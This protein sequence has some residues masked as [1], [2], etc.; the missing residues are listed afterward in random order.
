LAPALAI[1]A[2]AP[3]ITAPYWEEIFYRGLIYP[4]LGSIMP[5]S[6]ATPLSA[7]V[8]AVHHARVDALIPL[9]V[10]G[11][12]WATLYLLSGNL[13]VCMVVH[14]MW[15]SRIFLGSYLGF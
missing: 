10:L 6:L 1:G 15:N 2:I 13:F 11:M 14:A 3:C 7:I 8:F 5:M 9:F 4:F 12:T